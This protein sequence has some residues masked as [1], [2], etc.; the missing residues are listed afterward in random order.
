MRRLKGLSPL[1]RGNLSVDQGGPER[2]GPIPARA[3]EPPVFTLITSGFGAYPRSRGGTHSFA[4][5]SAAFLG[6][7]PLARGNPDI[8]V[9]AGNVD[10]PIPARAG[11]PWTMGWSGGRHWAYPRSRG[12]TNVG[13]SH[14]R[15]RWGLSPLARG[16]LSG[17]VPGLTPVRPIPARAGEPTSSRRTALSCRAYPRSRGGTPRKLLLALTIE[18]LSPLARGNHCACPDT[19]GCWG[20][21][22]ARAGEPGWGGGWV[23]CAGAYPRSR[24]GTAGAVTK[25][26]IPSGL[27]PLARGNRFF[28]SYKLG[29]DGP[30]PARAGEPFARMPFIVQS[31]AYPRSRGGTAAAA[32]CAVATTGLS[33]LARG[34]LRQA[35]RL[36]QAE[37]PIPARAGEPVSS[38]PGTSFSRAYPRSR[39]GTCDSSSAHSAVTGLS[40]LARGN[41]RTSGHRHLPEGPIPARAGE[42]GS[43]AGS[44]AGAGAYPR[45]RGGTEERHHE[46][47]ACHGLSPL[48]RGNQKTSG[49][50]REIEGPIPARAGEPVYSSLVRGLAGAYP[51]SRGGTSHTQLVEA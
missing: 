6:L 18:G 30:I 20:P 10:G 2:Q 26:K 22:P 7:S 41:H 25:V 32:L 51:R 31:G 34:N 29:C 48:A 36:A 14:G 13:A 4:A 50:V 33:P 35:G 5:S 11:E 1:A 38:E 40:P 19:W 45:S 42:P 23:L 39:G 28:S 27:S 15:E 9:T 43:A 37:G 24:G 21:I 17:L 16:N 46:N 49:G 12:G 3:G 47:V 44:C 8:N